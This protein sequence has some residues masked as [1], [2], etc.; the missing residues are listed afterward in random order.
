MSFDKLR[1]GQKYSKKDLSDLF[2][3]PNISIVRE[4]IYNLNESTSFFFVDLEKQGK[5]ERFHFDDFFEGDYF[6]WDSQTTQHIDTPKIQ[7]IVKG[8]RIPHLFI[9]VNKTIK[10]ITQP[11]V[12]CGQLKYVEYE[13]GT[14]K[15]VHIIFQNID[16]QEATDNQDLMEIYLWK[17]SK[18]GAS[19]R[20]K[21]SK[22]GLISEERKKKYSKPNKTE[23]KGLVTSRVGQGYHRQEILDK[24][25][26]QCAITGCNISRILISSHIKRWS[27]CSSDERL[28]VEN[29]ILLSPNADA[30]F[31]SY[32]I[33]FTDDG[34][35]MISNKVRKE[36]LDVLGIQHTHRIQVSDG[37]KKYLEHHR[38]MFRDLEAN[39]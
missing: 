15:P 19:S 37:M 1:I 35:I 20:S 9:R 17:P 33:S 23:R 28:D 25:N 12:Y 18:L 21:I 31:D 29:G 32:L 4:G 13:E 11:F 3:N 14:S 34:L 38:E 24:W 30:L 22:Q 36:Q 7:E 27:L 6:H 10:S 16:F 5:E 8:Q 2:N 39:N 26:N